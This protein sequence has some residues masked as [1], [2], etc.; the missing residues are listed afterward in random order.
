MTTSS[1]R[2]LL[3]LVPLAALIG[4]A[5]SGCKRATPVLHVY[6]WADYVKPELVTRFETE[7]RCKVVIDTFDSNEAMFAK[8]KAGA[9]GYDV[10]TPSSYMVSVLYSQG[11]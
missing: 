9:T 10:V 5:S 2:A 6:T 8:L 4:L 11:L 1:R 3:A 7:Q